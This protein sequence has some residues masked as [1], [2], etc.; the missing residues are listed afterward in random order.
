MNQE[1]YEGEFEDNEQR[2]NE[3]VGQLARRDGTGAEAMTVSDVNRGGQEA[4]QIALVQASFA[5]AQR[6]PR[7]FD[8]V[9]VKLLNECKRPLFAESARYR[10]E[11]GMKYDEKKEEW[12]PNIVEG[13]SIRFVEAAVRCMGNILPESEITHED[14]EKVVLRCVAID[15]E[16][17]VQWA[18]S[19]TIEKFIERKKL[20]KGQVAA[21][22]RVNRQGKVLYLLPATEDDMRL[23]VNRAASMAL[24]TNALRFIPG[25]LLDEA[26]STIREVQ[27]SEIK[28]DPTKARKDLVDKFYALGVQPKDLQE[29]FGGRSLETLTPDEIIELKAIGVLMREDGARWRDV[30]ATSPH[31]ERPEPAEVD[32]KA[33]VDEK[34]AALRERIDKTAA[35]GKAKAA[36]RQAARGAAPGAGGAAP[37]SQPTNGSA[38]AATPAQ[39]P[40]KEPPRARQGKPATAPAA[41]A[42]PTKKRTAEIAE[43]EGVSEDAVLAV[44]KIMSG[45]DSDE[46]I[47]RAVSGQGHAVDAVQVAAIIAALK[48][49][50]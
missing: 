38:P 36:E 2:A 37:G 22:T 7:D 11:Q 35:E 12:V 27:R 1:A 6:N 23:K 44:Q 21:R 43:Q 18:S 45:G 49:P 10:R 42:A 15:M 13:W 33:P 50:A 40:A 4:R 14:D 32:E 16:T 47:A 34:A 26:L 48:K 8:T 30:I 9:R 29:Y 20:A 19:T 46:T 17:N 5:I 25:D 28:R 3:R 31:I 39:A 41:P 24:R